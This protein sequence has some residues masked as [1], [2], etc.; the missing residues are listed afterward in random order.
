MTQGASVPGLYIHVPFCISKCGYCDFFSVTDTVLINA[1]L[2]ALFR[3]ID[4]YKDEFSEFD[5]IYLGGGTP[6]LLAVDRIGAILEKAHRTFSIA[7]GAEITIEVNPA[8]LGRDEMTALR[9]LGINRINIGVQSFDDRELAFLGR[10][11][12]G[13]SAGIALEAA[14]RAGFENMGLDLIFSL[15]GQTID[16]WRVSLEKGLSFRPEHLSCY[17]LELKASTPI[18][19][20][21]EQG[22][23]ESPSEDLK[24]EFFMKTSEIVEDAGYVHYE[25][26]NFAQGMDKASRHNRKYWDHTPYLGLGPAS[27]S[28][29]GTRRWWNHGSLH[30]YLRDVEEGRRP[31]AGSEDLGREELALEAL[32]LGLRMKEGIDLALYRRLYG[33]DLLKEKGS[34]LI[35]WMEAGLIE[36]DPGTVRPT[37]AGMAIADTLALL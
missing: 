18:G 9:S 16:A 5:T 8:D 7:A 36:I 27:H 15:P 26:S 10:R 2:E 13:D 21:Y 34:K 14:R 35:E 25:I 22:V 30:D 12:N 37:R 17:E 20:K 4:S 11:H 23:F 3:E 33:I 28:F 19:R 1:Y 29:N 31:V 24:R 6:S 32:F